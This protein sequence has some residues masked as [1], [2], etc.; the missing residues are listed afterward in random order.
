MTSTVFSSSLLHYSASRNA[1]PPRHFGRRYGSDGLFLPEPG[2]TVVCHLVE[3]SESQRAVIEA[4]QKL[5]DMPQVSQFAFTPISSL[6]MTLFQGIIEDR[7]ALPYWPADIALDTTIDRMTD[8]FQERLRTFAAPGPFNV[9]VIEVTPAGLTV[10]GATQEDRR[11]MKEWRDALAG[12]F[13][14]RHPDHDTYVFH[15]TFAYPIRWLD[16]AVLPAWQDELDKA[17]GGLRRKAPIIAL[18]P[19]AFCAFEDMNHFAERL[20]LTA[21][22]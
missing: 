2:N 19:P 6:H 5:L 14:Y 1:T 11:V 20:V 12:F 7:R 10:A 17:L 21:D 9:E 13:G 8:L 22:W 3:D 15:I 4:R 18:R 16:D